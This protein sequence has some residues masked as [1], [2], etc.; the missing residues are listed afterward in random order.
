MFVNDAF[1]HVLHMVTL[2]CVKLAGKHSYTSLYVIAEDVMR[3]LSYYRLGCAVV[4]IEIYANVMLWAYVCCMVITD[5]APALPGLV[6]PRLAGGCPRGQA[7][8]AW[9]WFDFSSCLTVTLVQGYRTPR[10]QQDLA[11]SNLQL[12]SS[13]WSGCT[14]K[15]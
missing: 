11:T 13:A 15:W 9:G 4:G 14:L 3:A 8:V 2:L 6:W 1:G 7:R 12:N 10:Q 5:T